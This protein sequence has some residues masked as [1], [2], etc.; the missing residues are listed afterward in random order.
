MKKLATKFIFLLIFS[1]IFLTFHCKPKNSNQAV[2]N[3]QPPVMVPK[4][5]ETA[6]KEKGIDAVPEADAIFVEWFSTKDETVRH[7]KLFRRDSQ[8][9]FELI[10]TLTAV[11]TSYLDENVETGKRY[12]YFLTAVNAAGLESLPS[13]T[14]S[15]KLLPKPVNLGNIL[16]VRPDFEWHF[17]GVPPVLYVLRLFQNPSKRLIWLSQ[18]TPNYGATEH[19][20]FNWDGKAIEDSLQ[21]GISYYWRVDEIGAELNCGSESNWKIFTIP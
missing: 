16:T 4:S 2:Q 10:I 3:P 9:G 18:V 15:Y 5:S 8:Q 7:W 12:F 21:R 19:V 14:V 1:V 20:R 13:D 11:D 17:I 6:G